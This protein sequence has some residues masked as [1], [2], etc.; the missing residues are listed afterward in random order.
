M[1]QDSNGKKE[2]QSQNFND[3]ELADIMKEIEGLEQEFSGEEST[4][5]TSEV[6]TSSNASANSETPVASEDLESSV[7]LR[8]TASQEFESAE[9]SPKNHHEDH[10]K[11]IP[12]ARTSKAPS[13]QVAKTSMEFK[14]SGTMCINLSFNLG[15]ETVE[16]TVDGEEGLCINLEG[17]AQFKLPINVL[18]RKSQAS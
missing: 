11:V 7:N 2:E 17:G 4:T 1:G 12:L 3:D 16:L 9:I 14:V 18:A 15:Q 10:N 6:Q 5:T 8:S 13:T